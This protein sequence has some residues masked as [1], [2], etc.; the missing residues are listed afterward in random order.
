[1]KCWFGRIGSVLWLGIFLLVGLEISGLTTRA[2]SALSLSSTA[3]GYGYGLGPSSRPRMLSEEHHTRIC[4]ETAPPSPLEQKPSVWNVLSSDTS[5]VL[6]VAV[7]KPIWKGLCSLYEGA[8]AEGKNFLFTT[9][10]NLTYEQPA[11]KQL[12]D[13]MMLAASALLSVCFLVAGYHVLC[14]ASSLQVLPR[15]LLAFVCLLSSPLLFQHVLSIQNLL[16]QLCLGTAQIEIDVASHLTNGHSLFDAK[17]SSWITTALIFCLALLLFFQALVRL[18]LLDVLW[19]ISPIALL[20]YAF[21]AWQ[22]WANLWMSAFIATIFVQFV[23]VVVIVLG[24]G[25]V[26]TFG[27]ESGILGFLVGSAILC[28]VMKIPG[29]FASA[30]C[31]TLAGTP[32][33][34]AVLGQAIRQTAQVGGAIARAMLT[35]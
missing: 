13:K 16:S 35:A 21:P 30:V 2:T 15:L 31:T 4:Q 20:C 18:A 28:L 10:S 6:R 1:M 12:H 19:V 9:G 7:L 24:V 22:R 25:L 8:V 27:G 33:T 29:W 5:D 3:P 17:D 34:T 26:S 14:G 32:S 23:Q 11:V